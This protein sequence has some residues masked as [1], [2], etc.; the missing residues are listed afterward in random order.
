[1]FGKESPSGAGSGAPDQFLAAVVVSLALESQ[2]IILRSRRSSCL[3][4][5][6][7]W[8]VGGGVEQGWGE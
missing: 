6:D 5:G 3:A 2:V 1:M 7:G 4:P 8:W